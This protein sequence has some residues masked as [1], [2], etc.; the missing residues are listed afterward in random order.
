MLTSSD[1]DGIGCAGGRTAPRS[2]CHLPPK[3]AEISPRLVGVAGPSWTSKRLLHGLEEPAGRLSAQISHD[4]VVREDLHLVVRERD[5][6]ERRVVCPVSERRTV[7]LVATEIIARPRGAGRAVVTV[8]DVQ[9]LDRRKRLDK[10]IAVCPAHRPHRVANG[11]RRREIKQRLAGA[12]PPYDG[13]DRRRRAICEKHRPR[14]R[15][16]RDH[17][18]RPIVF[19]VPPRPFVLLD[20]V[21][22]VLVKRPARGDASLLVAPHPQPIQ[23]DARLVFDDER[24][25]AQR[26]EVPAA[27]GRTPRRRA[28]RYPAAARSPLATRAGS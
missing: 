26:G 13:I 11:V 23:V 4:A 2:V 8:G 1:S 22:V 3:Y 12:E 14:L 28:G 10:R 9:R 18:P 17:V 25:A 24:R 6:E 5:A 21:A 27:R 7:A 16:D 20:D 19:L 15:A